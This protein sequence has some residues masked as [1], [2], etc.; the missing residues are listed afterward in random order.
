MAP[1]DGISSFH[2]FA[3]TLICPDGHKFATLISA[4][5]H[6]SPVSP[7]FRAEET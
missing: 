4:A 2:P 3:L 5:G 7:A 1:F 6:A